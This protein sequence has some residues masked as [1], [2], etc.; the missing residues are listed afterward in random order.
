MCHQP[1]DLGVKMPR[2]FFQ[3]THVNS[4]QVGASQQILTAPR[5]CQ[6]WPRR[7]GDA[8]EGW[9]Q[10]SPFV[11]LPMGPMSWVLLTPLHHPPRALSGG[12]INT[13][14]NATQ[15]PTSLPICYMN[16]MLH[17]FETRPV[18][19]LASEPCKRCCVFI[20]SFTLLFCWP[21]F[22]VSF[23]EAHFPS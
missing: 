19:D 3:L 17:G 22:I 15:A 2:L 7:L 13:T 11:T 6:A 9:S 16:T 10:G 8:R 12:T 18:S 21:S 1:T 14:F 4:E 23:F 5:P 20:A